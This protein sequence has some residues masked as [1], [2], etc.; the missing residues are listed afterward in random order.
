MTW[1]RRLSEIEGQFDTSF[2]K[3]WLSLCFKQ[4]CDSCTVTPTIPAIIADASG[5][6]LAVPEVPASITY[7]NEIKIMEVYSDKLLEISQ[8]NALLT[9]GVPVCLPIKTQDSFK[10]SLKPVNMAPTGRLTASGKGIIQTQHHSKILAF[11]ILTMLSDD[12][13]KV[14]ECQSDDYMWKDANGLDEEMDGMT[15]TALILWHLQPHHKVDMYSKIGAVKK[16]TIAQYDNDTDLFFNSIKSV[17]LQ[18]D[19]KDPLAYTNDA[20]VC[21][22]FVQLKNKLLPHVL[23]PNLLLLRDAG[24]WIR[25]L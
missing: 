16:M 4:C 25:K 12:A 10:S 2:T 1:R 19:S 22:I 15:I 11:L 20:F 6:I 17:K 9:C 23:S 13:R 7:M 8:K 5:G 21:D 14:I 3:I 24:K 18:V